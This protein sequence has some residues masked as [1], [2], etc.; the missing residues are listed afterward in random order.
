VRVLSAEVN[1]SD[2][3]SLATLQSAGFVRHREVSRY[4]LKGSPAPIDQPEELEDGASPS[5][6]GAR[7]VQPFVRK[8]P[9]SEALDYL[10]RSAGRALAEAPFGGQ[11]AVLRRLESK[12][13]AFLMLQLMESESPV[14]GAAV[15]ERDRHQLLA[16]G[17]Q[18]DRLPGLVALLLQR[19][20]VT[21]VDALPEGDPNH[22]VLVAAGMSRVAARAELLRVAK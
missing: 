7:L 15:I 21:V 22:E 18:P 11:P 19:H 10:E 16:L 2:A 13:T 5:Q 9:L 1:E 14:I 12:L 20:G 4:E 17:G 8:V 3:A 6:L